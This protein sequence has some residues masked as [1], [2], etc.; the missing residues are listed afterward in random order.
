MLKNY[1]N[2]K[3]KN[4]K[5]ILVLLILIVLFMLIILYLKKKLNKKSQISSFFDTPVCNN[6]AGY[7]ADCTKLPTVGEVAP[8]KG[9]SAPPGDVA[10]M[11][12]DYDNCCSSNN[13][14]SCMCNH[15]I[16]QACKTTYDTCIKN[17]NNDNNQKKQCKTQINTCCSNYN[18]INIDS[19]KF[20]NPIKR[21]QKDNIICSVPGE[22][23]INLTQKCMELCQTYPNCKAYTVNKTNMAEFSC[24]LFSSVSQEELNPATG[25]PIVS[26]KNDYYIKK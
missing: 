20:S 26:T 3:N 9:C 18:N 7:T 17:S 23:T 6:S 10:G 24:S 8:P 19:T 2:I 4:I 13:T 16:V 25:K 5:N 15:P 22:K 12:S 11:C 14:S 21:T 1:I